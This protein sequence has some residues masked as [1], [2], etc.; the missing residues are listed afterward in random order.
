[1]PLILKYFLL[2]FRLALIH[3][4]HVTV[5]LWTPWSFQSPPIETVVHWLSSIP[6]YI[7]SNVHKLVPTPLLSLTLPLQ[8]L[9][10][11]IPQ[12]ASLSTTA[13]LLSTANGLCSMS[14]QQSLCA[15]SS[16]CMQCSS[17]LSVPGL[18]KSS[19]PY[20]RVIFID[21]RLAPCLWVLHPCKA[22]IADTSGDSSGYLIH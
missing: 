13:L 22:P 18:L 11:T 9:A 3:I 2:M 7:P 17:L 5:L 19:N 14:Q 4:L 21:V 1:M 6:C 8:A 10:H 12:S 20:T 16:R 15:V